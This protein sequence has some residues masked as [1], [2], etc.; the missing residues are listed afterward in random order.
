[1]KSSLWML[2]IVSVLNLF[3]AAQAIAGT[4]W[5]TGKITSLM[6]SGANPAIRLSGN[7]SPDRCSG[8][9]YGWL[10]FSGTAEEKNRV[11][12]TALAMSLTGKTVTVYTNGDDTTCRIGNIQITSGLN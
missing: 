11:Y 8:G 9:T 4:T 3:F 6:A 2:L 5:A 12:S 7:I 10:Y 1:M